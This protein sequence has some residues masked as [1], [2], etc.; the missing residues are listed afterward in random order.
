MSF[1]EPVFWEGES[2]PKL[3]INRDLPWLDKQ[4]QQA[5]DIERF[6]WFSGGYLSL[7][8]HNPNRVVD[9]RYSMLPQ[10]IK[11]LWGIE[12]KRDAGSEEHIAYYTERGDAKSALVR[13]WQMINGS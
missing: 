11:P 6:R 2:I 7:D 12:L 1:N 13:L 4:S 10:E 9:I 8:K 3:N 5:K